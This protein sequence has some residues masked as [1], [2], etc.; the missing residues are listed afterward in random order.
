VILGALTAGVYELTRISY[1]TAERQLKAP[2][3]DRVEIA[4]R[5]R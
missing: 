4:Q 3:F 5:A 1:E 2:S